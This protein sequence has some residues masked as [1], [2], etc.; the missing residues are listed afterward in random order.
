MKRQHS[1]GRPGL[2]ARW[3]ARPLIAALML[4]PALSLGV[5]EPASTIFMAQAKEKRAQGDVGTEDFAA[6]AYRSTITISD[7]QP[8]SPYG[9]SVNVKGLKGRVIDVNLILTNVSHSRPQDI[10]VMLAHRGRSAV[11]MREA[12]GTASDSLRNVNIVLDNQASEELPENT[13]IFGDRAYQPRDYDATDRPF[14]GGAPGN[15]DGSNTP[16]QYLDI[17]NG[18]SANGAWTLWVRDDHGNGNSGSMSGWQLEIVTDNTIPY[19]ASDKYKTKLGRTLHVSANQGVLRRDSFKGSGE[20]SA[21]LVTKPKKGKLKFRSDGSFKYKPK[22]NKKGKDG[23]T[24]RIVDERNAS[25]QGDGQVIIK[26]KK[27]KRR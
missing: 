21:E 5:M 15:T 19:I 20:L 8:A 2:W 22:G 1:G 3:G 11:V 13:A 4:V 24:Y 9:S 7:N 26:I 10:S 18:L 27:N 6:P 16:R 12:G 23:F 14:G 17:F 25:I